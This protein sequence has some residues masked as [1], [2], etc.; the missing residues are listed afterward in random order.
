MLG[1]CRERSSL[2]W[3]ELLRAAG[4]FLAA[5]CVCFLEGDL[6]VGVFLGTCE[7][8][9]LESN[10]CGLVVLCVGDCQ[11]ALF[12]NTGQMLRF[13]WQ[14]G[15]RPGSDRNDAGVNDAGVNDAGGDLC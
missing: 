2:C 7:E 13:S 4:N 1:W 3:R 10:V 12:M 8:M 15:A 9:S 14:I 11:G 6:F 5:L